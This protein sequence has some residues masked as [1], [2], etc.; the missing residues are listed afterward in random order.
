MKGF[1]I[2]HL[3]YEKIFSYQDPFLYLVNAHF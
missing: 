1:W 2:G 3:E